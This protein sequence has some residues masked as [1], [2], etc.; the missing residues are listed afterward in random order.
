M[1]PGVGQS[2]AQSDRVSEEPSQAP[3]EILIVD[4]DERIVE[5]VSWFLIKRG[6]AVR[7][8]QNFALAR[9]LLA[10]KSVDLL[11]SD[12]D[13]GVE[14]ALDALP[15]FDAEGILPPTLVFSGYLDAQAKARLMA[16]NPVVGTLAKPVEFQVLESCVADYFHGRPMPASGGGS[17]WVPRTSA[18]SVAKAPSVTPIVSPAI[19]GDEWVEI[20][21]P[22]G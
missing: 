19:T 20:V 7:S 2:Q 11:L 21:P 18:A 9:T 16:L 8:A 3:K 14:S 6:Y 5:L 1:E 22:K 13:L 15:Q 4:N 17:D 12:I 10:E